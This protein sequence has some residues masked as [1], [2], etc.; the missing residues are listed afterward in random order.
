V[1]DGGRTGPDAGFPAFVE[2]AAPSLLGLARLLEEDPRDA[3]A[4]VRTSLARVRRRWRTHARRGDADAAAR[5]VL[6]RRVLTRRPSDGPRTSGWVDDFEA[7]WGDDGTDEVRRVLMQLPIRTR[8]ATVLARWVGAGPEEIAASL[9]DTPD[10]V[11]DEVAAGTAW[12]N[13]ALAPVPASWRP[14]GLATA[15]LQ[16]LDREL[17]AIADG[18]APAAAPAELAETVRR[19]VRTR[20]WWAAGT[21]A[22][23]AVAVAVAVPALSPTAEPAP[24]P[25]AAEPT[26]ARTP[27]A[28]PVDLA[29]LSVRG[30][31][32]DD[33]AFLSGLLGLSWDLPEDFGGPGDLT[34]PPE[35][36]RVLFAGD[37]PG[38]R[39]AL[40]TGRPPAVQP[41]QVDVPVLP[42]EQVMAWFTGTPG[43]APADM[44]MRSYP[45]GMMPGALPALLDPRTGTMVVLAAP[46]D[47]VEVSG[48]PE[49][50]A[51]GTR[52]RS[53]V[54]APMEDGVAVVRL[55][56]VGLP[57]L[58]S[59]NFR[60]VSEGRQ[61][62][63]TGMPDVVMTE[64]QPQ[65]PPMQVR[66]PS[67]RPPEPHVQAV[68]NA[69]GSV[70]SQLGLAPEDTEITAH[71]TADLPAPH[72]GELALVSVRVPS[73]ALVVASGWSQRLPDGVSAMAGEC[74]TEV[75][76]AG[77][78]AD[79]RV[80]AA[81]CEMWDQATGGPAGTVLMVTVPPGVAAVRTYDGDGDFLGEHPVT[82]R[83][84]VVPLP[85]GTTQVEAVTGSGV[86]LG[87]TDLLPM[88]VYLGE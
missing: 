82:G 70:L 48:R 46:G 25:A 69:A 12:L 33:Q 7:A 43:A 40:L 61:T 67:G 57:W 5:A 24:G 51:D 54:A 17:A 52:S 45:Y 84:L 35:T 76:P 56:A 60:L 3:D 32:A 81:A 73:G 53:W 15:P 28:P 50:A 41:G 20:R 22:A 2:R 36:R 8:A 37:V 79:A 34:P 59:V 1:P 86:L 9:R 88:G 10:A 11:R 14:A 55:E 87:R 85:A 31:L 18:A 42:D 27:S 44:R 74:G 64:P 71:V 6:V 49:I 62:A 23:C 77:A 47:V 38:G 72:D 63:T 75:R 13:A 68:Q 83:T 26:R 65:M 16:D 58:W 66:Y 21:A 78:P 30:S 80:I 39:W 19:D 29:E 4:L